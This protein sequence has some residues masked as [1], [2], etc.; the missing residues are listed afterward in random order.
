MA[1]LYVTGPCDIYVGTTA[2]TAL[3]LGHAERTPNAQIR[4]MFS[5]VFCDLY[6]QR[7]QA[8]A[9]YDGEE[10][11][12]SA[13]LTRFNESLYA[14][15]AA[16]PNSTGTGA[17]RGTNLPGDIGTL[18]VA[19][20]FAYPLF[21]R[22]PYASK[23][24]FSTGSGGAMPAGYRFA[25]CYLEGPDDLG[26]M[27]TTNRRIRLNWHAVRTPFT[28]AGNPLGS[29]GMLLYDHNMAPTAGVPAL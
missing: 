29:V 7:I 6:G 23:A 4:P 25:A 27:A 24:A 16:R 18:M 26:P 19:E 10:G 21:L 14:L 11:M 15:I 28:V 17:A 9:I 3:F 13:D 22:F 20:G 12:I 8:D 5:P 1:Q 2:G